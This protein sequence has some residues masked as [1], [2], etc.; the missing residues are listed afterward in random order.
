MNITDGDNS[1]NYDL[2]M[3]VIDFFQ[4]EKNEAVKNKNEVLASVRQ[5]ESVAKSIGIRR[6]EQ[7]LMS[8]AFNV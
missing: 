5:W 8:P 3:Q 6:G 2:A 4:L 1:L 7:Q